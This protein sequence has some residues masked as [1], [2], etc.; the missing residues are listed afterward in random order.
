MAD[1]NKKEKLNDSSSLLDDI[2]SA[3]AD[4]EDIDEKIKKEKE[5]LEE[6]EKEKS[7]EE[8]LKKEKAKKTPKKPMTFF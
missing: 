6:K 8:K 3:S 1:N 7:E 5:E 2:L 4:Q